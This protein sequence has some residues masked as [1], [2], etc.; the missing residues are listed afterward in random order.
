MG[1]AAVTATRHSDRGGPSTASP[2]KQRLSL[3]RRLSLDGNK[4][5]EAV[6]KNAA[7]RPESSDAVRSKENQHPEWTSAEWGQILDLDSQTSKPIRVSDAFLPPWFDPKYT[8][9]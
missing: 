1:A 7:A 3:Q 8:L 6:G 9:V 2:A 5:R 4:S